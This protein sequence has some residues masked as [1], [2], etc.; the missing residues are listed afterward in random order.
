M[1]NY[2]KR[3]A[4][5]IAGLM[6]LAFGVAFSIRSK[7]GVSPVS[8][9]P[10]T[11]NLVTGL[12]V[13]TLTFIFFG[14]CVFGQF[15]ILRKNFKVKHLLQLVFSSVFAVFV[16]FAMAF[17]APIVPGSYP[18]KVMLLLTSLVFI[19]IAIFF[20]VL[21]DIVYNAPEGFCKVFADR[22]NLEFS[23]VKSRFD[24]SCVILSIVLALIFLG[25]LGIVREG[26]VIAALSIGKIVGFLM[27]RFGRQL[28]LIYT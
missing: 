18:V 11:L 1:K 3:L 6:I 23:F 17:T 9:L 4:I 7:L 22:Y 12:S 19:G 5:Y 21:T 20:L 10:A 15:L 26:T 24:I 13:G 25:N 14:I 16:D 28:T 8:S 2:M 27:K